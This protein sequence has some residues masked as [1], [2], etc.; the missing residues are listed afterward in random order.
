MR[1]IVIA[2][3][4]SIAAALAGNADAAP[5]K[6]HAGRAAAQHRKAKPAKRGQRA[7][8]SA[9]GPQHASAT[10]PRAAKRS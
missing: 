4:F 9:K 6:K 2:L 1:T 7:R 5:H 10:S 3:A 8:H